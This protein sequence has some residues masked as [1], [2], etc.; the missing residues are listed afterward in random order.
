[1][2]MLEVEIEESSLSLLC[3]PP[4]HINLIKIK[5]NVSL[6]LV[7]TAKD[8]NRMLLT[9]FGIDFGNLFGRNGQVEENSG[10]GVVLL[11]VLD[12]GG[13]RS[14]SGTIILIKIDL[15]D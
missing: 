2:F 6:K 5:F 9:L 8:I 10:I 13:D 3:K 12:E 7:M 11:E 1:M 14:G 4:I 15:N